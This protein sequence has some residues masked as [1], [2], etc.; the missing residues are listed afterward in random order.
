MKGMQM[1]GE[2]NHGYPVNLI[3]GVPTSIGESVLG[4]SATKGTMFNIAGQ[5]IS[6]KP[7]NGIYIVNGKK[8]SVK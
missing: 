1:R 5:R 8:F 3:S 7:Q 6:S 4:G 2:S